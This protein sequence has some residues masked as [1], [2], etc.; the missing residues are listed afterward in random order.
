MYFSHLF[1]V[2]AHRLVLCACSAVFKDV[3]LKNTEKNPS[4]LLFDVEMVELCNML[5]FMYKGEVSVSQDRLQKFLDLAEKL[6]VK[7]LYQQ[8]EPSPGENPKPNQI[9]LPTYQKPMFEKKLANRVKETKLS[10]PVV[11]IIEDDTDVNRIPVKHEKDT[12]VVTVDYPME[13]PHSYEYESYDTTS[14]AEDPGYMFA[15]SSFGNEHSN[16]GEY[17]CVLCGK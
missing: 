10:D 15:H 13:D 16:V 12:E 1:Q 14:A 2:E 3:I 7:G 9:Q 5:D 8:G 17:P 11:R 6:E 4:I